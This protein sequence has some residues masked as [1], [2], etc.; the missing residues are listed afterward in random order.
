MQVKIKTKL[1]FFIRL[2]FFDF[3]GI[4]CNS[5]LL[6]I[7]LSVEFLHARFIAINLVFNMIFCDKCEGELGMKK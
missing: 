7:P 5:L 2:K 4:V 1:I 6:T 3:S